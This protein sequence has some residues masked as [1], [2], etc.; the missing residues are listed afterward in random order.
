MKVAAR[1]AVPPFRVMSIL[2]RVAQ[3]RAAG[4]DVISLCAGE[5]EDGTRP[6]V[7]D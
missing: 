5:P 6:R 4:R 3:L 2:D 1:A 7:C